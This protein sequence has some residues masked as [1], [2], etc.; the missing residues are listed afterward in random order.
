MEL[1]EI[2]RVI[3]GHDADGKAI[4]LENSAVQNVHHLKS[5]PGTVF[6]EVWNTTS[7]PSISPNTDDVTTGSLVLPPPVGGTR[8]RFVDIP[9]DHEYIHKLSPEEL[10]AT[11]DEIG[12]SKAGT[13]SKDSRHPLM[14]RTETID[15]GIVMSG[16]ITLLLDDQ[17]VEVGENGVIIQRGTNHA[18][19]NRTDKV[20]RVAFILIDAHFDQG[21]ADQ[22]NA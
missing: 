1:N 14:H 15:Y 11:F 16:T 6:Y 8:F 9:P 22:F 5:A 2:K 17:E 18:W 21:L 12:D 3:T 19:S 10:K 7:Q 13:S 4:V 20:C